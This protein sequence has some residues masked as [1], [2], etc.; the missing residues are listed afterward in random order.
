MSPDQLDSAY[1]LPSADI[2]TLLNGSLTCSILSKAKLLKGRSS[3]PSVLGHCGI[4]EDEDEE[5]EEEEDDE[6]ECDED[7][8]DECDEE[9]EE[10]GQPNS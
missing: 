4:Y 2:A 8:E 3:P 7:E 1:V 10:P 5:D 6:D 9:D